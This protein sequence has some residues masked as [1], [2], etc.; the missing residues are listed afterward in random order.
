MS[1]RRGAYLYCTI[2]LLFA[3]AARAEP[4]AELAAH[5]RAEDEK[6]LV[7]VH[8]GQRDV[9]AAATTDDFVY[10]EEGQV[11]TRGVF[12]GEL[13]EDGAEPL[14]LRDFQLHR[15]GDTAIV[16]HVDDLPSRSQVARAG[17]QYLMTETWQQ[18]KGEWKLRIVHIDA[19]HTDPPVVALSPDELDQLAGTYLSGQNRIVIRRE[20]TSLIRQRPGRPDAELRAEARDV[21]Y[22]PGQTRARSIFLRN[23]SGAVSS[24]VIRDENSDRV[25]KR[26]AE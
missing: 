12:L 6:L 19:V 26:M 7:A 20:G 1:V 16:I 11:Q 23:S 25:W 17:G 18:I 9:W 13:E 4:D 14:V 2:S 5:L 24:L 3:L 21:F 10:V 15:S 22:A 8:R